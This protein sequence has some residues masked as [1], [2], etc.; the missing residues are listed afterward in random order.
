MNTFLAD[1]KAYWACDGPRPRARDYDWHGDNTKLDLSGRDLDRIDATGG[2]FRDCEL[3]DTWFI[4]AVLRDCDF[5]GCNLWGTNFSQADLTGAKFD[6]DIPVVLDL[7]EK[8]LA[9]VAENPESLDMDHYH[10]NCGSTHCLAGWAIHLAGKRGYE[11]EERLG[12]LVAG[13]L[14]YS[15]SR[16]GPLPNFFATDDAALADLRK[17]VGIV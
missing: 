15:A 10:R 7:D 4:G 16:P 9:E 3:V 5:R 14:I 8:I 12:A 1:V 13:G 17:A 11:L 2:D 6:V